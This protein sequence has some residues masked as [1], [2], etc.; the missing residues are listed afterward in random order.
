MTRWF[1]KKTSITAAKFDI[2]FTYSKHSGAYTTLYLIPIIQWKFPLMYLVIS[3]YDIILLHYVWCKLPENFHLRYLTKC[4]PGC[5]SGPN[6]R[7]LG[8]ERV[9]FHKWPINLAKILH[10]QDTWSITDCQKWWPFVI[11]CDDL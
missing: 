8:P 10:I 4:T 7:K 1:H 11:G 3:L 6:L 2:L 5:K 9:M